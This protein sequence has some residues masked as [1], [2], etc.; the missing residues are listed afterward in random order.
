MPGQ[1]REQNPVVVS[2]FRGEYTLPGNQQNVPLGRSPACQNVTFPGPGRVTTRPGFASLAT[3]SGKLLSIKEYVTLDSSVRRVLAL[4]SQGDLLKETGSFAFSTIDSEFVEASEKAGLKMNSVTL[5]GKEY[6][7]LARKG[8]AGIAVPRQYDDV[9][10]DRV[11]PSGPG[12][13]PT[14]ATGATGTVEAGVRKVRVFFKTRTGYWT[15]PGPPTTYTAPGLKKI[16]VSVIPTGPSWVTAR[17]ICISP[18]CS[19]NLYFIEGSNM[20]INDNSTTSVTGIDFT[21][22]QLISGTVVS[23]S[24]DRTE[25]QLNLVE[26]PPQSAFFSYNERLGCIGERNAYVLVGDTKGFRNLSFD[27]G[28]NGNVPFGWTEIVSGETKGSAITGGVGDVLKITGDG[29]N[30]KGQIRNVE[31]ASAILDPGVQIKARV[32]LKKSAGAA[33]GTFHIFWTGTAA[34]DPLTASMQVNVSQLSSTEWR[35]I[36]GE[37]LSAANNKPMSDWK[38]NIT[39]GGTG[40]GGT[41]VTNTEWI[42]VDYLEIFRGDKGKR[43]SFARWSRP[44]DPEAF[45]DL[46]GFQN[47]SPD[48]GQDLVT[49]FALSGNWYWVKERSLHVTHDDGTNEPNEWPISVVSSTIGTRSASGVGYG[50]RWVVIAARSGLYYFAGGEPVPI[51]EGYKPTW[52]RI[53]W[54]AGHLIHV[55]V[56][57]ERRRIT[58]GVPLDAATEATTLLVLE[59]SG[60]APTDDADWTRWTVSDVS[61]LSCSTFSERNDG[62]RLALFGTNHTSGKLLKV[63]DAAHDD[64]GLA[65]D[66]RYRMA[67]LGGSTGRYLAAKMTANVYGSGTLSIS[68]F[69]PDAVTGVAQPT[70]ALQAAPNLDHEWPV[71]R[72]VGERIAPELK[73]NAVGDWFSLQKFALYLKEKPFSAER[74]LRS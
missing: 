19:S 48:D 14:V 47:V 61:A 17:V 40:Y 1:D 2:Q 62:S 52:D 37:V 31:N 4:T 10:F 49:G 46:N 72:V 41:A 20:V 23:S 15:A 21:D 3:F 51:S 55:S 6:I 13:G 16:D 45:D 43:G 67:F 7:A 70:L 34:P 58:V 5:Y 33:A 25:D 27:G 71:I 74:G 64:F 44:G 54:V 59:W 57:T 36:E 30:Q 65:I 8:L 35:V 18:A 11:A 69:T 28:F 60:A 63:D 66:S 68:C 22:Q 53:N 32:R 9:N 42:A 39:T 29:T 56:D 50:D 73:T 38:L 24:V 26:L 12:A